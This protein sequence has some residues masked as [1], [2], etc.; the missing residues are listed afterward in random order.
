MS[1]IRLGLMRTWCWVRQR[2]SSSDA[3]RS[4]RARTAPIRL[5]VVRV[6]LC[7]ACLEQPLGHRTE[8][9]MLIPAPR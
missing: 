5:L 8:G 4:P 1:P 3:A 6:A 9:G 2:C 7:R